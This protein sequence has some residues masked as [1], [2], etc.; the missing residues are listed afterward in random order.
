MRLVYFNSS[1]CQ[2]YGHLMMCDFDVIIGDVTVT[3]IVGK[4]K[5]TNFS[6]M[7]AIIIPPQK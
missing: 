7:L 3:S 2:E 4:L 5:D 6:T 1:L